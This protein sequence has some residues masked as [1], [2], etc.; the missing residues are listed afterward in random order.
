MQLKETQKFMTLM[1]D[2]KRKKFKNELSDLD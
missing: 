2:Q 1:C